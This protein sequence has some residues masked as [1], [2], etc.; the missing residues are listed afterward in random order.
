VHLVKYHP[1]GLYSSVCQ[2][3]SV[4]HLARLGCNTA[5]AR[6][7]LKALQQSYIRVDTY[8]RGLDRR[9]VGVGLLLEWAADHAPPTRRTV[10]RVACR[11][12]GRRARCT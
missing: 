5:E 11:S 2:V 8:R 7:A 4:A 10:A 6:S 1:G 12:R 3:A 9:R